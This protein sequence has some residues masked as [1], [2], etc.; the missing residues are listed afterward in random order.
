MAL[1]KVQDW[2]QA[3]ENYDRA[4]AVDDSLTVAYLYR[5]GVPRTVSVDVESIM[6]ALTKIYDADRI[7]DE[8]LGK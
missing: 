2:E 5:G 8:L 1:E 6:E 4:I 7:A 3:L